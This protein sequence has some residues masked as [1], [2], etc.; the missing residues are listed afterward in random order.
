VI[1]YRVENEAPWVRPVECRSH[2]Y[3]HT[4]EDGQTQFKNTHFDGE[5][6][7][8]ATSLELL[9]IR[10][11]TASYE[12]R[13]AERSLEKARVELADAGLHL[14]EAQTAFDERGGT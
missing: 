4:D 3:P 8:W 7:A 6:Q 11:R 13:S 10:L 9:R 2:G 14:A 5:E 1:R 12:F